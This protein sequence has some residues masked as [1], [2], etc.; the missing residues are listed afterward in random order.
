MNEV[1][2]LM[3]FEDL[4]Y[5]LFSVKFFFKKYQGVEVDIEVYDVQ[6]QFFCD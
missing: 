5:D 3:F 1:E 4:G 6:I 2:I